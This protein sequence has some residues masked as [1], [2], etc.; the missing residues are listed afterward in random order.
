MTDPDGTPL[1]CDVTAANVADG[2][3][4][5]PLLDK[6]PRIRGRRGRP[7]KRPM[8][9]TADKAYH[10]AAR[11]AELRRRGVCPL[12]PRRGEGER[13]LGKLRWPIERT[14]SWIKQFRRLRTR[15]ERRLDIHLS[16][17][18]LACCV[19]CWRRLK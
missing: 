9:V 18:Q 16:F 2:V 17:L 12:L 14:V 7:R 6:F 13:G 19:I 3:M 8:L 10:S 1:A 4:L 11:V 5:L 15:H